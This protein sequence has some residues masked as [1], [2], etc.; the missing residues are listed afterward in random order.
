MGPYKTPQNKAVRG[1]WNKISSY[2][3]NPVSFSTLYNTQ[4]YINY[5]S[6]ENCFT[7]K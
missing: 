6:K 7:M 3:N 1:I 4:L 5:A 2:K